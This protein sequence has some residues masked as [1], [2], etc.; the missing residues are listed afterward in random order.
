MPK[1]TE[2]VSTGR[3][4]R[5]QTNPI[6]CVEEHV[7]SVSGWPTDSV[8][9]DHYSDDCLT[10]TQTTSTNQTTHRLYYPHTVLLF[11]P[12][13]PGCIGWYIDFLSILIRH[14]GVGYAAR[15]IS[16]AGH[17]VGEDDSMRMA[18]THHTNGAD[19]NIAWTVD[20]QV[21]HKVDWVDQV[22]AELQQWRHQATNSNRESL[23]ANNTP[24]E[25]P[26]S[27]SPL[28]LL[29]QDGVVLPRFIILS[30][31]IGSHLVQRGLV[32]RPDILK[33]T[34]LVLHLMPF[35][36]FDPSAL[37]P[38]ACLST[39][40]RSPDVAISLLQMM[41]RVTKSLP[42][43][44]IDFYMKRVAGVEDAKGR[45]LA[46]D[47]V[48]QPTFAKNFLM[49]GTEEVRDIPEVHD[50]STILHVMYTTTF[51]VCFKIHRPFHLYFV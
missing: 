11:V 30:H 4:V 36:R 10:Q 51:F 19:P 7:I 1:E 21:Q 38:K 18:T 14:L 29:Q 2:G 31:S 44:W 50:V 23:D 6:L 47:I 28:S 8:S 27:R 20:G 24:T 42:R 49:L 37:I 25:D 39:L 32:L 48:Q 41:S 46:I 43:T 22:R 45:Q 16:Y 33:Q 15:G 13:N 5:T 35:V 12:G 3:R 40:A 9:I 34:E 17:G 26:K